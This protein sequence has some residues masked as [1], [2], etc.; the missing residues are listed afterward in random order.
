MTHVVRI[1]VADPRRN[2]LAHRDAIDEAVRRVL[3]SGWYILGREVDAFE[4]EFAQYLGVRAA[5][6]VG[7]GTEALHLALRVLEV[8]PGDAVA[9][10]SNTAVAT[11]AAIELA[12]ATPVLVDVDPSTFTLDPE[13][14]ERTIVGHRGKPIKAVILVHLYGHPADLGAILRVARRH[15]LRV[16]EDCAQSSGAS[17]AGQKTGTF[18]DVAAFSFYPTKNLGALGDGGALVTGDARLAERARE[19]R[20]YGWRERYISDAAGMNTRLDEIQAAILRVKLRSLEAENQT[21]REHASV[22]DGALARTR[23]T[24]PA[25]GRNVLHAYHQYTVRTKD[26]DGLREFLSSHEAGTA[27]L[28]P[29]PIHEQPAYRGRLAIGDG[30]LPRTEELNREILCLPMYPELTGEEVRHIAELVAR[31][32]REAGS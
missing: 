22:Y 13:S 15:G 25:V 21:R 8:G 17:V 3:G 27:I 19:L 24:P 11:V 23:V 32:S 2:Y 16:I 18:G 20:Q 30:G 9:T 5:V 31:W 26:R 1:P 10:V 14:L 29:V 6:G 12:G 28:Y 4:A 7:S